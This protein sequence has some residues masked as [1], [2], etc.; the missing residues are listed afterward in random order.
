LAGKHPAMVGYRFSLAWSCT[1]LGSA[2]VK[3]GQLVEAEA[4][5]REGKNLLEQLAQERP[6]SSPYLLQLAKNETGMATLQHTRGLFDDAEASFRRAAA[7]LEPIVRQEPERH[8]FVVDLALAYSQL[9][10]VFTDKDNPQGALAWFERAFALLEGVLKKAPRHTFALEFLHEAHE[11]R[12]LALTALGRYDDARADWEKAVS[13]RKGSRTTNHHAVWNAL[14][15]AAHGQCV[16]AL[17]EARTLDKQALASG[18]LILVYQL[19]KVYALVA[20][21][22]AQGSGPTDEREPCAR[23]AVELLQLLRTQKY[24][25]RESKRAAFDEER[26]FAPLRSRA[27]FA[28]FHKQ[29]ESPARK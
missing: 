14:R 20:T 4:A 18:D 22:T 21:G 19:A 3:V 23:R 5:Y 9:G 15:S 27:D 16:Q 25:T 6:K 7:I 12:A 1:N 29:L 26:A 24:F 13:H 8:E 28:S 17:S 2:Y 10:I 11:G